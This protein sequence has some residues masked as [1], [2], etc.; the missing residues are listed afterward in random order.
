VGYSP[1]PPWAPFPPLFGNQVS[2][3]PGQPQTFYVAEVDVSSAIL[4]PP[5][6]F[7]TCQG[8]K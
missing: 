8:K 4:L 2:C 7:S 1:T 5:S 6:P 3:C